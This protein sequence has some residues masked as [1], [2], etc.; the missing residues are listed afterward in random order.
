MIDLEYYRT[1]IE[2]QTDPR[3]LLSEFKDALDEIEAEKRVNIFS[4]GAGMFLIGLL[5]G[6][7]ISIF[8]Y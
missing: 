2:T 7:I 5:L 4:V 8:A 3:I 6:F 1:V